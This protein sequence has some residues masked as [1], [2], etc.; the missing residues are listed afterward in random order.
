MALSQQQNLYHEGNAGFVSGGPT[1]NYYERPLEQSFSIYLPN[2]RRAYGTN[3]GLYNFESNCLVKTGSSALP[4]QGTDSFQAPSSGDIWADNPAQTSIHGHD[5]QGSCGVVSVSPPSK[6]LGTVVSD[7]QWLD[8][9]AEDI[10][11]QIMQCEEFKR[12][13]TKKYD[14]RKKSRKEQKWPEI[15]ERAFVRGKTLH[16]L[17]CSFLTLGSNCQMAAG[18]T[19]KV[20]SQRQTAWP[21]RND[22]Y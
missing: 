13:E 11:R 4:L 15:L 1:S 18:W 16:P 8:K 12:Y 22:R 20:R 10:W 14:K 3:D 17:T 21:E 19:A 5:S 7:Q 6:V 9:E 2:E